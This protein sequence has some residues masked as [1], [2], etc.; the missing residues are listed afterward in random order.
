MFYDK[1][2]VISW[3]YVH[4][5]GTLKVTCCFVFIV[6][7]NEEL[8]KGDFYFPYVTLSGWGTRFYRW[9]SSGWFN[10]Q[11]QLLHRFR[12]V[13]ISLTVSTYIFWDLCRPCAVNVKLYLMVVCLRLHFKPIFYLNDKS[14]GISFNCVSFW[15][16]C[17]R[18][19]CCRDCGD[20]RLVRI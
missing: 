3:W 19:H 18:L 5:T 6:A 7:L 13:T 16:T 15:F 9:Q 12:A 11:I 20:N 2:E 14:N 4:A 10:V 1:L 8:I 17:R